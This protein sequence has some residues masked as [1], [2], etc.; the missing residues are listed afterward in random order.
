MSK[1]RLKEHYLGIV[2]KALMEVFNYKNV[3]EVPAIEKIIINTAFKSTDDKNHINE[4]FEQVKLISGQHPVFTK[5]KKSISNFKLRAGM[6][7]GVKVTLRGNRMY[8]FLDRLVNI[9]MPNI[10]D[11]R[12]IVRVRMDGKGNWTLGIV[13]SSIFPESTRDSSKGSLGMDITFVT[14]A[15]TDKEGKELLEKMGFPFIKRNK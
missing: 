15:K 9:A 12:G 1:P 2:V 13:D 11:F 10:R 8:E 6:P 7:I 4:V 14:S 3:H 5:A